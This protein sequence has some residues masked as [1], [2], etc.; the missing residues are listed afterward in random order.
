MNH[1]IV[2]GACALS[3]AACT[4]EPSASNPGT[5]PATA[6]AANTTRVVMELGKDV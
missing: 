4:K 5:P 2:S 3:L 1:W 6:P